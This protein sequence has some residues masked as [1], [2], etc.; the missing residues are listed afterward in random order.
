MRET[1]RIAKEK[2]NGSIRAA[3]EYIIENNDNKK[4]DE[5]Y[6]NEWNDR[7]CGMADVII[8]GKGLSHLSLDEIHQLQKDLNVSKFMSS[9]GMSKDE[10]LNCKTNPFAKKIFSNTITVLCVVAIPFLIGCFLKKS[11]INWSIDLTEYIR[12]I[13]LIAITPFS[14]KL[15]N[16]IGS[17]F[18]F[19]KIKDNL[20]EGK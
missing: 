7:E 19:K 3:I 16:T 13:V 14:I 2:F 20:T 10:M 17:Y 18:K 12:I 9:I 1:D 8:A 4:I 6:F 11:L 5:F 15:A